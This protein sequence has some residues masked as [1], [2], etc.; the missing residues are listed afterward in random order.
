M[1]TL[2]ELTVS[3]GFDFDEA[4]LQKIDD[5]IKQLKQN[6]VA[7]AGAAVAAGGTL[8]AFAKTTADSTNEI[9]RTADELGLL[10][11]DLQTFRF[12]AEQSGAS[13][14][15]MTEGLRSLLGA[16]NSARFGSGTQADAFRRLGITIKD[17]RGQL[18]P[19][20][21]VYE[22]LATSV[23]RLEKGTVRTAMVQ[24]ILGGSAGKMLAI[25]ERGTKPIAAARQELEGFGAI[26][27]QDAFRA[28]ALFDRSLRSLI[29]QI[30]AIGTA[31]GLQLVPMVTKVIRAVQGWLTANQGLLRS[32]IIAFTKLLASGLEGIFSVASAVMKVFQFLGRTFADLLRPIGGLETALKAVAAALGIFI[33][34][35]IL[36]ALG[37]IAS[38]F[39]GISKA[40]TLVNAKALLVPTLIGAAAAA[41]FLIV[42]DIVAFVDGRPSVLGF[43]VKNAGKFLEQ[44]KQWLTRA[45]TIILD[46]VQFAAQKIFEFFGVPEARARQ[47]ARN[48]RAAFDGLLNIV[49]DVI[50]VWVAA[51][52]GGFN[53]LATATEG[54]VKIIAN[55]VSEPRAAIASLGQDLAN[56][57]ADIAE[58]GLTALEGV[59]T[60]LASLFN[61]SSNPIGSFWAAF[62]EQATQAIE[63]ARSGL[64]AVFNGLVS[65]FQTI[66]LTIFDFFAAIVQDIAALIANP[67]QQISSLK[68]FLGNLFGA[69][70]TDTQD[71]AQKT[72]LDPNS[73]AGAALKALAQPTALDRQGVSALQAGPQAAAG[74]QAPNQQQTVNFESTINV[75]APPGADG[76]QLADTV[77][78]AAA[79][80]FAK[81]L[82]RTGFSTQPAISY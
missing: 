17:N 9:A 10:T 21:A 32:R 65:A 8:F 22:Q 5:G 42:E 25:L 52:L 63:Y 3:L 53:I 14:N 15:E 6:L 78:R 79:E 1:A 29:A 16:M 51:V 55:L 11:G 57:F 75:T 4:Q 72:L 24:D 31:V 58:A 36:Q 23:S 7:V 46:A 54:F 40:L 50:G 73:R 30:K 34:G 71:N 76:E 80:E 2:R 59:G 77:R 82:R 74:A 37:M 13:A 44:F 18:L 12:L 45:R 20:A 33:G 26:I 66:G 41:I 64:A 81:Q 60:A 56:L 68:G 49:G 19:L 69:G 48:I 39:L 61:L 38:G 62:R 70:N 47:A 28:T 67:V 35:R 43:L 27:S